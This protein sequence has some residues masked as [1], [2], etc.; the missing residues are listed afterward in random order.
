MK[1]TVSANSEEEAKNVVRNKIKFHKVVE[2]EK[3]N[4]LFNG[5]FQDFDKIFKQFDEIFGTKK[6]KK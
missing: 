3:V 2:E 1:T 4:G 6:S 5:A